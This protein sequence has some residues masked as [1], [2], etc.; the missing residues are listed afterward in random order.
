MDHQIF[1]HP[2]KARKSRNKPI[3]DAGMAIHPL[4]EAVDHCIGLNLFVFVRVFRG[5]PGFTV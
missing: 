4:G 3:A 5:H 2:R 1:F